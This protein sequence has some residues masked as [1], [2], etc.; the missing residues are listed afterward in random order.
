MLA[1]TH[2]DVLKQRKEMNMPDKLHI[3]TEIVSW[4][5]T[6]IFDEGGEDG[7]CAS[8]FSQQCDGTGAR[9]QSSLDQLI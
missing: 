8:Q 3:N 1:C 5:N 4:T 9:Q 2:L 6:H 7:V